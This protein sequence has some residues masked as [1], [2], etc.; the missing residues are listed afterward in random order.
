MIVVDSSAFITIPRREPEADSHLQ[1]I[2]LAGLPAVV[3]QPARLVR[4][5]ELQ[6]VRRARGNLR[7]CRA[8]E[9]AK[10]TWRG[11]HEQRS[12]SGFG[13]AG[14]GRSAKLTGDTKRQAEGTGEKKAGKARSAVRAAKDRARD[15]P[16]K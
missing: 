16:E 1:V 6:I 4:A 3:G 8:L 12:R 11:G 9:N 13:Q 15:P 14:E 7:Q 2:A 5:A 10:S